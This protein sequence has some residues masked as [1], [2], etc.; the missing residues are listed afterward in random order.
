MSVVF[1]EILAPTWWSL[2]PVPEHPL[3]EPSFI[4]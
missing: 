4:P 3:V 1:E 2:G